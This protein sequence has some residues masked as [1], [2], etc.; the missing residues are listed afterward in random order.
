MLS[1]QKIKFL[2]SLKMAKHRNTHKLFIAEGNINVRD[3]IRYGMKPTELYVTERWIER[4]PEQLEGVDYVEVSLNDLKKCTALKNP[5]EVLAVFDMPETNTD[6]NVTNDELT[7]VLDDIKDPGNFGTIIRS[8]D[9]FGVRNIVCS[10]ETVDAYNP[11]VVQASMGSIAR[12]TISYC[13]LTDWFSKIKEDINVFGAV[14]NGQPLNK[15]VGKGKGILIIGS[16]AH[17]ISADIMK[18]VNKPITIPH[19]R[20]GGAE[21]LNASIATAILLYAF[22]NG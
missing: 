22:V 11:K 14:L 21:S 8:A 10:N 1:K 5:S 15:S 16:E 18:F 12:I 20:G 3:F 6:F 13:D 4:N 7:L 17:G 2:N 19:G 9:W